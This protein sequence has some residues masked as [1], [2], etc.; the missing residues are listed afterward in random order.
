MFEGPMVIVALGRWRQFWRQ[1]VYPRT[2]PVQ[3][4][5]RLQLYAWPAMNSVLAKENSEGDVQMGKVRRNNEY[6]SLLIIVRT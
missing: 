2:G 3:A 6:P 5:D 1:S 4:S